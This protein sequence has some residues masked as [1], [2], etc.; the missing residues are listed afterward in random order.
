MC[1]QIKKIYLAPCSWISYEYLKFI[2]VY[3]TFLYYNKSSPFRIHR[4]K[5]HSWL[6]YCFVKLMKVIFFYMT[7]F[8]LTCD[9]S[10]WRRDKVI[11]SQMSSFL[12]LGQFFIAITIQPRLTIFGPHLDNDVYMSVMHV[13][14]DPDLI[15][16]VYSQL[17][18]LQIFVKGRWLSNISHWQLSPLS[19]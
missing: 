4:F 9:E 18:L 17:S 3:F 11:A 16:M 2:H 7:H 6:I 19:Y 15:F 8:C 5:S 12:W 14:S 1:Y 13:S 10:H